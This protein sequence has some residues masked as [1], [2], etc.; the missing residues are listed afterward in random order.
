MDDEKWLAYLLAHPDLLQRHQQVLRD[1]QIALPEAVSGN[2]VD[3]TA[4]IATKARIEARRASDANQSLLNVAAENM[5][6][7]Q[8]LH[9]ATLGFLA[10]NELSGFS[11]MI[12][13]ELPLIFGLASAHLI[14][15]SQY[16][17]G[18]ILAAESLGIIRLPQDEIDPLIGDE[19]IMM[20]T[21]SDL[22]L[23]VISAAPKDT[24][25]SLAIMRLPD[26]LPEP[27]SGS[28]LILGGTDADSFGH[29]K[30]RTL[31]LHLSE[32]VGVCL[33]SLIEAPH[34]DVQAS[35]PASQ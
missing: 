34:H 23:S 26:Q 35:L 24:P 20:G 7:W 10:C 17:L 2:V 9:L 27:I 28:V 16:D 18:G 30:G 29:G 1:H 13:E 5:L 11:Q 31:L 15:P 25:Q 3:V 4:K 14:M 33:L 8:E 6:H 19:V 12:H 21:P 32:M 22:L